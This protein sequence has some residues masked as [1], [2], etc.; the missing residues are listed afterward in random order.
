MTCISDDDCGEFLCNTE[1]KI[2]SYDK[3]GFVTLPLTYTG[4]IGTGVAGSALQW[5]RNGWNSH[6][7]YSYKVSYTS[8]LGVG[9]DFRQLFDPS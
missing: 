8:F 1:T 3:K 4:G 6:L 9:R 2:C 7:E 5:N